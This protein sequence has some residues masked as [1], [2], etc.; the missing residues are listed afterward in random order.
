VVAVPA[1]PAVVVVEGDAFGGVEGGAG[2]EGGHRS[3]VPK[4]A[5]THE[6]LRTGAV[7]S[8]MPVF[9]PIIGISFPVGARCVR[10][11]PVSRFMPRV[12]RDLQISEHRT[13][14]EPD[15]T[16]AV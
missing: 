13:T 4:Q 1:D 5:A 8:T 15:R 7:H 2:R 16:H 9:R 10:N 11:N 3:T 6:V 14:G 12:T